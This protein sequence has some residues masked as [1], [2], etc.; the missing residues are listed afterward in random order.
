MGQA[1]ADLS[2]HFADSE[3]AGVQLWPGPNG[4]AGLQL[5]WSA[6]AVI[7]PAEGPGGRPRQGHVRGLLMALWPALPQ[8]VSEAGLPLGAL[9]DGE[10][11]WQGQ[12]LRQLALPA[13]LEGPVSL[14]LWGRRGELWAWHGQG[15]CCD[16]EGLPFFE[17]LAC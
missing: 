12:R 11:L 10:V 14:R 16:A 3:L 7:A 8:G 17:S 5:R 15:L 6:A 4:V 1:P 13:R 9:L 2:L